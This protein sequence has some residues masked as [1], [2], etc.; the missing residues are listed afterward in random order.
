MKFTKKEI[1]TLSNFLSIFRALLVIPVWIFMGNLEYEW[2][3]YIAGGL[4]LFA[5]LTDV[6][7]GYFARK[8]N[9]VTEFGKIIDPVADKIIV[10]AV[11]LKLFLIEAVPAYY[12]FIIIGRDLLILAGGIYVTRLINKVLPSNVLGKITVVF[13]SLVLLFA[14]LQVDEGSLYYKFFYYSSLVLIVVSLIAYTIRAVEF[15]KKNKNES[16]QEF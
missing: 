5:A 4:C 12:F 8:F 6:L 14:I 9:Q 13:I 15:I 16:D 3:R 2:G 1:L 10:S 11:V 7:D